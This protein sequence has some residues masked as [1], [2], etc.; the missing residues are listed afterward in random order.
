[1]R[2]ALR[3]APDA[4]AASAA[5]A[6]SNADRAS[7]GGMSR[8]VTASMLKHIVFSVAILSGQMLTACG[9]GD[10]N[11]D[12][13][14]NNG[15]SGSSGSSGSN[16]SN[17]ITEIEAH[18]IE[19]GNVRGQALVVQV[20]KELPGTSDDECVAKAAGVVVAINNGEIAQANLVLSKTTKPAVH[21]LAS[22]IVADCQANNAALQTLMQARSATVV[23]TSAS[24]A[25]KTE[26]DTGTAQ[27]QSDA[28]DHL[29]VDCAQMQ[30]AANQE[31]FVIVGA[32][33]DATPASA[34]DVRNLLSDTETMIDKHRTQAK[35]ALHSLN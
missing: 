14:D 23:D 4:S 10:D 11:N 26:A 16:G 31:A 13:D 28:A 33:R 2:L 1:M 34:S 12:N 20:H 18:A 15:S 17:N 7:C 5:A 19:Q 35:N 21:D 6:M 3:R 25:L 29:D 9:G 27:L 30:I 32:V 8:A 24:Q 22:Q